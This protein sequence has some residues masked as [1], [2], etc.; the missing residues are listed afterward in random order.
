MVIETTVA[1]DSSS[2]SILS[3]GRSPGRTSGALQHDLHQGLF[4]FQSDK[5]FLQF[6]KLFVQLPEILN[7]EF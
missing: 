4:G 5:E 2:T 6:G 7:K 3:G 1:E